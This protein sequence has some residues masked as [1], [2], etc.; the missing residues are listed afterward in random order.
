MSF[1]TPF[2]TILLGDRGGGGK[3]DGETSAKVIASTEGASAVLDGRRF[4]LLGRPRVVFEGK[5]GLGR[6]CEINIPLLLR[7]TRER[8]YNDLAEFHNVG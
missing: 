7:R 5:D 4:C 1:R 3:R 6:V 2:W 8:L